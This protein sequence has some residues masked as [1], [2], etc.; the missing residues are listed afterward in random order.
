MVYFL[1]ITK[2]IHIS[3]KE[4]T[5]IINNIFWC[6]NEVKIKYIQATVTA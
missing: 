2:C 3:E 4:N 6:S 1:L 5:F